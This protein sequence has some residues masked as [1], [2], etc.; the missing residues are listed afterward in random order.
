MTPITTHLWLQ[1]L[2]CDIWGAKSMLM[3][4]WA[5]W[6]FPFFFPQLHC[7][8]LVES[9]HGCPYL[10]W[11]MCPHINLWRATQTYWTLIFICALRSCSVCWLTGVWWR[12][13]LVPSSW[14][15]HTRRH[16][17]PRHQQYVQSLVAGVQQQRLWNQSGLSPHI[18]K[19]VTCEK[20]LL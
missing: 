18:H 1:H 13:H 20:L 9:Q 19:W 5:K 12:K 15:L 3:Q 17:G 7:F 14:K 2:S 8:G 6:L 11:S 10:P 16:D 4:N